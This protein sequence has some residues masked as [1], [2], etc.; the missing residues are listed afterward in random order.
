MSQDPFVRL[1][2]YEIIIWL[3]HENF[4]HYPLNLQTLGFATTKIISILSF[5]FHI[6][7]DFTILIRR[8]Y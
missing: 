6:T 4:F 3:E 5:K 2:V 8:Q 1:E 7:I